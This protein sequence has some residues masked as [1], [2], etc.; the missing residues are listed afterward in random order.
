MF[1]LT[2][3]PPEVASL[4]QEGLRVRRY[5]S[6]TTKGVPGAGT[7]GAFHRYLADLKKVNPSAPLP[8][9]SNLILR[10]TFVAILLSK[11][12]VKE[13]G[14]NNRGREVEEFQRAASWMTGTGWAWCAAFIG[15]GFDRLADQYWLPFP[16][17]E[18]AGAFWYED[19]ATKNGITV[20][21]SSAKIKKGDL[22]IYDFSHIEAATGDEY[23]NGRFPAV[24]GN[25]SSGDNRDGDGVWTKTPTKTRIRSILRPFPLAA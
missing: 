9:V 10:D 14:G 11:V 21:P 18:G 5:Y 6:G 13:E 3:L 16:T 17:P 19:W 2:T 15:W 24:G 8:R 7:I 4:V 25:T 1:D 12:G 23:A 22:I 20:L